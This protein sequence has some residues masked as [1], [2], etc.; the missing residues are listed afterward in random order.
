MLRSLIHL[1]AIA[2]SLSASSILAQDTSHVR[3]ATNDS[4]HNSRPAQL[5]MKELPASA[6]K[7]GTGI[8]GRVFSVGAPAVRVGWTPPPF[9]HVCTILVMDSAQQAVREV[10]TDAKGRYTISL[11]PGKYFL[12]VKESMISK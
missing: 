1:M 2:L 4:L 7:K 10:K 11:P 6:R 8:E 5:R 12:S 3:G 9:E